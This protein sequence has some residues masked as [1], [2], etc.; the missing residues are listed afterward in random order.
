MKPAINEYR[1][2]DFLERVINTMNASVYILNLNPYSLEWINDSAHTYRSLGLRADKIIAQGEEAATLFLKS[3]D[4]RESVTEA[5]EFAYQ[6]PDLPW[7][8]IFRIKHTVGQFR[9]I[10]ATSV[11]FEKDEKGIP[12]KTIVT[13]LDLTDHLNTNEALGAVLKETR[14]RRHKEVLESLTKREIEIINLLAKG[15]STKEIAEQLNR[16]FHT[17]E[18][19][20]GNIKNK[21]GCKNVA[22]IA[23]M[24]YRMGLVI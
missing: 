17:I 10:Y 14:Q 4:F 24:G 16:S 15:L 5:V 22:E 8:G 11:V 7:Y 21:L 18:T 1:N 2:T 9:W 20:R 23:T 3:E 13:A 12:Q 19:H 6:N